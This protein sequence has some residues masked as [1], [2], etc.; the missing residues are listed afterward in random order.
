MIE[1]KNIK[2]NSTADKLGLEAGDKILAV[3]NKEIKEGNKGFTAF[4]NDVSKKQSKTID[5]E[6]SKKGSNT[7]S[8]IRS[9]SPS[10]NTLK[11]KAGTILRAKT[12]ETTLNSIHNQSVKDTHTIGGNKNRSGKSSSNERPKS[13]KKHIGK[14]KVYQRPKTSKSQRKEK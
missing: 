2:P 9:I 10:G 6:E 13:K 11:N 12:E 14:E 7:S 4:K 3:N 1:V 5:H 8:S